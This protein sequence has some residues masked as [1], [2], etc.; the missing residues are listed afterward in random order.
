MHKQ[1]ESGIAAFW[2]CACVMIF[3]ARILRLFDVHLLLLDRVAHPR[4][5]RNWRMWSS[6]DRDGRCM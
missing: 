2:Q 6:Q 3:W 1:D 4:L 5:F